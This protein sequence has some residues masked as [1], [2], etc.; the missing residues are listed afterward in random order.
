MQHPIELS[1]VIYNPMNQSFEARATVHD[2]NG[3]RSYGCSVAAPIT[4][5]FETAAGHLS[6]EARRRHTGPAR[7]YFAPQARIV[8]R[9][10]VATRTGQ[11]AMARLRQ[12]LAAA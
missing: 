3:A 11:R 4:T 2:P 8:G 10:N 1:D 7:Q 6:A 12:L 9:T 5:D